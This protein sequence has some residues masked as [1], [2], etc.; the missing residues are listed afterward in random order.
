MDS[1]TSE[2]L[3]CNNQETYT[4]IEK[5]ISTIS[6]CFKSRRIHIGMDEANGIGLGRYKTQF[7]SDTS[8]PREI[9]L[10]HLRRVSGICGKYG[11]EP[12]IWSDSKFSFLFKSLTNT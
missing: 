12:L 10:A 4:F 2:V 3:L 1:S 8:T 11:L 6:S 9:L 5:M 7:P